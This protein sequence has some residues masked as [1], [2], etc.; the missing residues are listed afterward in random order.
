MN[1]MYLTDVGFDTPNS[2]NRLVLSMLEGFLKN[3]HNVYLI[4]SHSTGIYKDIP[5]E[6]SKYKGFTHDTVYKNRVE[7][8]NFVKRY[9]NGIKYEFNAKKYWKNRIKEMDIVLLQSHFTAWCAAWLLRN[10]KAKVVFNIYDI[11][12]GEAYVNGSIK[13]KFIYDSLAFIQKYL[14]KKCDFF[15]VLSED[16]K[17]TL[18]TLGVE[19]KKISV[20]PVWFEENNIYYV[21]KEKN[22]FALKYNLD[23][24]KKYIQYAG[25]IGVAYDFDFVIDIAKKLEY[26]KDIIFQIVGEGIKLES[27]KR[28]VEKMQLINIQFIPW[29]PL[30][31]LSDVYSYC[32]LE[33]VPLMQEVIRNSYPSKILPV[34]A[35]YRV[36]VISVE[37]DSYFYNAI[38]NN[39]I[40]LTSP[41][42]NVEKMVENILY[43]IDNIEI[44]QEYQKNANRYVSMNFKAS[45]SVEKMLSEFEILNNK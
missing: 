24:T 39:K 9:L 17:N 42:G 23:P 7:K 37:E 6:L 33:I 2:N 36:P 30:E 41:I 32:T 34:M 13:N 21:E 22:K 35:C 26:R 38:N 8:T 11:F 14:Y 20:T 16:M 31:M 40:G 27:M 29:Q 5:D 28:K 45:I 18:I 10:I 25:S 19:S 43:L 15:F 12:P 4:Q 3:G 44:L 1:I